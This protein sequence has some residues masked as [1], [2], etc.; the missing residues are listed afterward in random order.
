MQAQIPA[1]HQEKQ[2]RLAPGL[3]EVV[4]QVLKMLWLPEPEHSVELWGLLTSSFVPVK[5][6]LCQQVR[7]DK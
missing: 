3:L 5:S 1:L 2:K 4:L 7:P 6:Y